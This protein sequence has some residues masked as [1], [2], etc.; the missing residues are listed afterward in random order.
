MKNLEMNLKDKVLLYEPH[1]GLMGATMRLYQPV[2]D[3]LKGIDGKTMTLEEAVIDIEKVT[4]RYGGTVE[5]VEE[6]N[7]IGYH[8][9]CES[10][11]QH[12]F[13]LLKY[14]RVEV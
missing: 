6:R 11:T 14:E 7:F 1:P 13:R 3:V 12:Y 2:V 8:I 10:S 4:K 9:G 5:V